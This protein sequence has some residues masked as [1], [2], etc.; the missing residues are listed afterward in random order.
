MAERNIDDM[1]KALSGG[2]LEAA[3]NPREGS[4]DT[5]PVATVDSPHG[6]TPSPA[7]ERARVTMHY[8][9]GALLSQI[10][11]D[12]ARWAQLNFVLE[13]GLDT[14]VRIFAP[15]PLTE[16]AAY[17]VFLAA[18]ETVNLRALQTGHAVKI[19]PRFAGGQT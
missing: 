9:N 10:L 15:R 2:G 17:D 14:A 3:Q 18:L 4:S 11:Q 8:P 6:T 13:P 5:P 1:E 7:A 16:S 19:V 12:V